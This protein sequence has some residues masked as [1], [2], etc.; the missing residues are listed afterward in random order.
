MTDQTKALEKPS[1]G[2]ST[3]TFDWQHVWKSVEEKG[4]QIGSSIKQQASQIDTKDLTEKAKHAAGEGLK[5]ARGRSDNH[6]ANQIS[7][8]VSQYVPGAGLLRKGAEI[9]HETGADGKFL[10]GK[11]GALHAPSEGSMKSLGKEA[12]GTA[13]P[14]PGG[15][16][17]NEALNKSGMKDKL[18]DGTVDAVKN[19]KLSQELHTHANPFDKGT[20][21]LPK[22]DIEDR[23]TG[24]INGAKDK[25]KALFKSI[26]K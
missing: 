6:Q 10:E 20:D 25:I 2:E 9:A 14:I 22:L 8:A 11:K 26:E 24:I 18:V 12:L 1:A 3:K 15:V 16:W 23:S 5:I 19:H 13:I 17:A 7:D 4:S 21:K